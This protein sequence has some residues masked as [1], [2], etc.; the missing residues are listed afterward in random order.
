M[1]PPTP[2]V[3]QAS[4][5]SVTFPDLPPT[6]ASP[7][8]TTTSPRPRHRPL[9][10]ATTTTTTASA[11][12]NGGPMSPTVAN[13]PRHY[14]RR[15]R[16]VS[17]SSLTAL[18][19]AADAHP[20][21]PGIPD[22]ALP[23]SMALD[24]HGSESAA[25]S[26]TTI[27]VTATMPTQAVMG[28]S[29]PPPPLSTSTTTGKMHHHQALAMSPTASSSLTAGHRHSS[30]SPQMVLPLAPPYARAALSLRL[31]AMSL[32]VLVGLEIWLALLM[33]LHRK[34]TKLDKSPFGGAA[35][36]VTVVATL[37]HVYLLLFR[38]V[39]RLRVGP[40]STAGGFWPLVLILCVTL[41]SSAAVALQQYLGED[42]VHHAL[43]FV[44]PAMHLPAAFL[45]VRG[46]VHLKTVS[47]RV[48]AA[49]IGSGG[50]PADS[51]R[52]TVSPPPPTAAHSAAASAA[53]VAASTMAP[54]CMSSP[55]LDDHHNGSPMAASK[56]P[57]RAAL[58]APSSSSSSSSSEK[59]GAA[60]LPP[61]VVAVGL[62]AVTPS[63]PE[64][65]PAAHVL[66]A[67]AEADDSDDDDDDI[68]DAATSLGGSMDRHHERGPPSPVVDARPDE[69]L[70][71]PTTPLGSTGGAGSNPA[72]TA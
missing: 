58:L 48:R 2:M 16:T 23:S 6:D 42:R 38:L 10:I 3:R 37:L 53:V 14:Y 13:G 30:S 11:N 15:S 47:V 33:T 26:S 63:A 7:A 44:V 69:G 1:A 68:D 40:G 56:V 29:A 35:L 20:A 21:V 17:G 45:A 27:T 66:D 5:T 31:L 12:S 46:F 4:S 8:T 64:L 60:V 59:L 28:K 52:M 9:A 43:F 55:S 18:G 50:G 51:M 54:D 22:S 34:D 61:P 41:I 25:L 49:S 70:G 71:V 72:R 65:L 62:P 39:P 57:L 67:I 19:I 24:E 32:L 36:V